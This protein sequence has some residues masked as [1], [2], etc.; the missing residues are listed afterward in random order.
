[1]AQPTATETDRVPIFRDP[2]AGRDDRVTDLMSR[3]TPAEKAGLLFQ[4]KVAVGDLTVGHP[5]LGTLS[6]AHMVGDLHMTHFNVLGPVPD[7]RAF[8]EWHNAMQRLAAATRLGIPI[9]FSTDPRH[10]FTDNVGTSA[11]AGAFSQWPEPLGFGALRSAA[12]VE[13]FADIA[14]QEYLAVG[15]RLA[16]HPQVDLVTEPRWARISGSFSE[17][18]EL[19]ALL[20]QAYIHGFQGTELGPDSVSTVT[21]HFPGGGPQ[22]DGEDPHFAYGREQVYPGDNFEYHLIPFRAAIA[23]GAAQIMPYYAMPEGTPYEEVGFGFNRGIVTDLL[24]GELGF[25]GIV[26]SDWG[27]VTDS[28]IFGQDMPARAWGVEH[29]DAA[30]RVHRILDAGCDQLGGEAR[31]ELVLELLDEGRLTGERLDASVR[32]L[33]REKFALGLFDNQFVDPEHAAVVVGREDFVAAGEAA[34]RRAFT[35]L[36]NRDDRLPLAE[37][38]RLYVEGL[39]PAVAADYGELVTSPDDADVALLRLKAPYEPRSGSF[40]AVFHAGSLEFPQAQQRHHLE[41]CSAVPTVV[42]V[43]LDRPAVLTHLRAAAGLFASFGGTDAAFLD[44][45][46]GRAQPH[47]RL[48]FD[49]PRSMAAVQRSRPDVPFDTA[50]PAFQ[51]GAGLSYRAAPE[52]DQRRS[53]TADR[54]DHRQNAQDQETR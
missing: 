16:L 39:D 4:T 28:V 21:K 44:V 34:Q 54:S 50:D 30:S 12:L 5:T 3:M 18:A 9:T 17:D 43:Y 19:T 31:P 36:V 35:L 22:K 26:C 2:A 38:T 52:V 45:V 6:A 53:S 11:S 48:P 7:A 20:A 29:L 25:D 47:G 27:L 49:L 8:A 15:L 46:F 33:L 41:L 10:A 51:F 23:A 40:E 13:E 24:R 14:R 32:R 1:M 42:D 37:G